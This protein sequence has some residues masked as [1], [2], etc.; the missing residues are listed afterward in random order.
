MSEQEKVSQGLEAAGFKFCGYADHPNI[1]LPVALHDC[2]EQTFILVEY[3]GAISIVNRNDLSYADRMP[4][5][6]IDFFL[7]EE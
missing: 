6:A 2:D 1:S 5:R 4:K 3:E 7:K